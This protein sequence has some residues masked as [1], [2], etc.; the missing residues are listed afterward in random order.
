MVRARAARFFRVPRSKR[1]TSARSI[2][3]STLPTCPR[4]FLTRGARRCYR[5]KGRK[6]NRRHSFLSRRGFFFFVLCEV[7]IFVRTHGRCGCVFFGE[8]YWA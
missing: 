2:S 4:L 6:K 7:N 8:V 3:S 5:E 1:V